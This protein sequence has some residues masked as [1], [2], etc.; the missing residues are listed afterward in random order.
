MKRRF[1][2]Q[3]YNVARYAGHARTAYKIGQMAYKGYKRRYTATQRVTS[4]NGVTRQTDSRTQ[5]RK[6]YMPKGKK[7][8]WVKFVKK[9]KAVNAKDEGT[10]TVVLNNLWS[11]TGPA[12]TQAYNMFYLYGSR[13]NNLGNELGGADLDYLFKNGT[14]NTLS[15]EKLKFKSAVF[16]MTFTNNGPKKL[17]VDLYHFTFYGMGKYGS[18]ASAHGA[19]LSDTPIID[20]NGTTPFS[21]CTLAAR[22]VTPFDLPELLRGLQGTIVKKVK[23]FVDVD[24]EFTYQIRDAKEHTISE[25]NISKGNQSL[26]QPRITQG[27]MLVSKSIS[28]D[29]ADTYGLSVRVTRKYSWTDGTQGDAHGWAQY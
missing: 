14:D 24:S 2:R 3:A 17:E 19:A 9:V 12:N 8:R 23:Y 6:R 27:V 18:M 15:V 25:F 10:K 5:Y 26:A 16:D 13:N 1:A 21:V 22:G 29:A 20:P 4:G 28:G 11:V 7:R